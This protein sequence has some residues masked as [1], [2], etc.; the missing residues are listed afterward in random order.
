MRSWADAE[1]R[2]EFG[3]G[4][5]A[6]DFKDAD[7]PQIDAF[8]RVLAAGRV[9]S[10]DE[11]AGLS[12]VPGRHDVAAMLR[13]A[14]ALLGTNT[15][16]ITRA[17]RNEWTRSAGA[18]AARKRTADQP[19]HEQP[20]ALPDTYTAPVPLAEAQADMASQLAALFD[21]GRQG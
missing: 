4:L 1:L 17:L 16:P 11:I 12:A 9:P 7:K 10:R 19:E 15:G 6:L 21:G 2:K 20:V 8:F 3:V 5:A 13:A 18:A 14:N